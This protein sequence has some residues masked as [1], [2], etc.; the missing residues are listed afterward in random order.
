MITG[1]EKRVNSNADDYYDYGVYCSDNHWIC[2]ENSSC[3]GLLCVENGTL[4][5]GSDCYYDEN[6]GSDHCGCKGEFGFESMGVCLGEGECCNQIDCSYKGG[7][8]DYCDD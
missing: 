3:D 1:N 6:C 7:K 5:D 2:D 4:K 8:Y